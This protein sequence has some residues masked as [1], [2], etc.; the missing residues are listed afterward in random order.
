MLKRTLL[1]TAVLLSLSTSAHADPYSTWSAV[2]TS[3]TAVDSAIQNNRYTGSLTG[4]AHAG[5]NIDV[6]T[7]ICPIHSFRL[8]PN[9]GDTLQLTFQDNTTTAGNNVVA[10]LWRTSKTTASSTAI[11]SLDSDLYDGAGTGVQSRTAAFTHTFDF[12]T[13]FY[14]VR[15]ELER[16]SSAITGL[17]THGVSIIGDDGI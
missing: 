17:S 14:F 7:L 13:Y 2:A 11:V 6:I 4:V 5:T 8:A 15:V 3:C 12:E 10:T 9:V 16:S 1:M